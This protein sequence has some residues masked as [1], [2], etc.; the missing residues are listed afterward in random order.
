MHVDKRL[1]AIKLANVT[2]SHFSTRIKSN[3]LIPLSDNPSGIRQDINLKRQ[4]IGS[5]RVL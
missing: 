2:A 4:L 5:E 1:L 3:N